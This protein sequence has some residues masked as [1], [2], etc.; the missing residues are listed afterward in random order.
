[1]F[2]VNPHSAFISND[3]IFIHQA[4][5][6]LPCRILGFPPPSQKNKKTNKMK[7]VEFM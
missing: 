2:S 5:K 4:V 1:M 6:L 3:H 7:P